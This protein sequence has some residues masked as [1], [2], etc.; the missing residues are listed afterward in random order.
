MFDKKILIIEDE[1]SIGELIE[2]NVRKNGFEA[3]RVDSAEEALKILERDSFD[4][5]LLDLMLTGMDGLDFCKIFKG[6]SK[7][8]QAPIIMLTARSEDADIVSGLEFGADDYMTKHFSPRVLIARIKARLRPNAETESGKQKKKI[9]RSGIEVDMECHEASANG[10]PLSLTANEFSIL[11]LFLSNPGRV[12]T[13][14]DIIN[15]MH[16]PGY[17]VTD[18]AID[19]QIVGLRKKLGGLSCLIETVRGVGYRFSK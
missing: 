15:H 6:N 17:A 18:R 5:I 1:E 2:F 9:S 16:G 7:Y 14:D 11:A 10:A 12:Y 3:R 8:R 13:R 19:V 4:L